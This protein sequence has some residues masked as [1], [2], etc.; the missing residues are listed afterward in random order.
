MFPGTALRSEGRWFGPGSAVGGV[1]VA[2]L[3]VEV[4]FTIFNLSFAIGY[5]F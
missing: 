3:P 4:S 5:T 1:A 2:P